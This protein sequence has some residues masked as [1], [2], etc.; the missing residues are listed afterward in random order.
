MTLHNK[1]LCGPAGTVSKQRFF[2][3]KR[4]ENFFYAQAGIHEH[5]CPGI[6]SLFVASSSE[7]ALLPCL[8]DVPARDSGFTLLEMIV[9]I[10]VMGIAMLLIAGFG[11]PHS[12]RLETQ[13]AAQQVA[14]AMRDARGRA[15]A[16]GQPVAVVLPRLPVWLSVSIQAPPG[17]IVFLPDGSA[18]GG[19]VLLGGDRQDVAVTADWL[20]GR[21]Q[22][23]A[24]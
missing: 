24:N 21:V 17:G 22:I 15:I 7:K 11:P 23:D 2:E 9:V 18:S 19:R 4:A 10:A 6:E 1:N 3:K 8:S 16:Q 14:E 13:V 12:H 20:T 5:R